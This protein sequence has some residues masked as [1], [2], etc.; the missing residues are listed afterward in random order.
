M[1]RHPVLTY[2]ILACAISWV[3]V[4]P[5]ILHYHVP[6]A[7]HALGAIGPLAA[8]LIMS[9]ITGGRGALREFAG[10]M[11]RWR[12]GGI[13]W[14]LAL[15]PILLCGIAIAAL[16][17]MGAPLNG[18]SALRTA[19]A[20]R[21]W[22]G[23]MF[24]ASLAYGV[25][26]EPGWRGFAL[27]RLMQGRT[28]FRATVLLTLGWGI[29]HVPY[30]LYRYHLGGVGEYFGFYLGLF[31]GAVWLTFLYNSTGGS[32][33]IVMVWHT[34]WN[35][36]ALVGAVISPQVVAV[37]STLIMISAVIALAVS[38][39]RLSLTLRR[40]WPAPQAVTSS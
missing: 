35:A 32:T 1:R 10:R 18:V 14:L 2:F 39:T 11:V 36:V 3:A 6:S 40:R 12:V 7:W 21:D 20:D 29:W 33:L 30:F 9:A 27:P 34:V 26:E 16:A 24:L 28:A 19:F 31:A 38:G 22:L 8:A 13:A 37:T 23:A 15:S 17:A 5:L 4:S 25:G